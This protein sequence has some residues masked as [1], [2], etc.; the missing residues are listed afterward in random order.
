[1]N[2]DIQSPGIDFL[3]VVP[4]LI[5]VLAGLLLRG[6]V[7]R[8]AVWAIAALL[9]GIVL[10][11][12]TLIDEGRYDAEVLVRAPVGWM[13]WTMLSLPGTLLGLV[14]LFGLSLFR[15]RRAGSD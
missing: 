10:L 14:L 1:M 8:W 4:A 3:V 5:V 13:I 6:R 9:P 15:R 12:L 7:N 11:L 2:F